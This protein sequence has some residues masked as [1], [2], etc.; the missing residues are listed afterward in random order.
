[1][2]EPSVGVTLHFVAELADPF[3]DQAVIDLLV[4]L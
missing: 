2:A 1:L 3:T 4:A